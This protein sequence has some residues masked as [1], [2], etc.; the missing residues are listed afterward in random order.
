MRS[1]DEIYKRFMNK[2]FKLLTT[3]INNLKR[4]ICMHNKLSKER[5]PFLAS[6][7]IITQELVINCILFF[8]I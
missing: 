6:K 1:K 4:E 5:G 2:K 8:H 7:S 3:N